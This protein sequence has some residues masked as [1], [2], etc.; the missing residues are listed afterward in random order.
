[1]TLQAACYTVF[2]MN[3]KDKLDRA[4]KGE[5]ARQVSPDVK[6]PPRSAEPPREVLPEGLIKKV[7]QDRPY[8]KVAKFLLLLGQAEAAK[9]MQHLRRDE[10]E[11]IVR[12]ISGI[13][14]IERD[15]AELILAEFGQLLR[16][17]AF[18]LE[19][20]EKAAQDILEQAFGRE[21]GQNILRKAL[22]VGLKP[23]TFMDGLE[24]V[25]V[26][27]IIKDE[28]PQVMAI[29][30]PYLAPKLA[31][32]VILMLS[33]ER[34]NETIRRMA[35]LEKVAPD[36]LASIDE[37][38]RKKAL[39]LEKPPSEEIDGA[40]ALAGILRYLDSE[41]EE[42]ILGGLEASNPE[43]GAAIR[44]RLFTIDDILRV[45]SKDLQ[46]QLRPMSDRDL[47]LLLKG[48]NPAFQEK[49]LSAIS[50]ERAKMVMDEL[51]IM[52]AVRRQDVDEA[53]RNF[54]FSLK[55]LHEA[56]KLVFEDQ[57]DLIE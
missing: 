28:S 1:M 38:L 10:L 24:A 2:F 50:R 34:R 23:F 35:K 37:G 57:D 21:K 3:M 39:S 18:S 8:R 47:A 46:A 41:A 16:S 17:G 14:S 51:Q 49:L 55:A 13:K 54:L 44:E 6:A 56:G 5:A 43:L 30:L 27:L 33:E 36:I 20:G 45:R 4:Y 11:G 26:H 22:P 40:K 52:G 42:T 25:Q 15:E 9:V 12:E 53:T 48:K 31:S 19:G 32:E 29:V 7:S